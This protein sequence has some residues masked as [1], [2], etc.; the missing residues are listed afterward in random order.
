MINTI[1]KKKNKVRRDTNS[2]KEP[3]YKKSKNTARR[4]VKLAAKYLS[5]MPKDGQR[6]SKK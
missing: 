1:K 4:F 3:Q 5:I 2:E 6:M